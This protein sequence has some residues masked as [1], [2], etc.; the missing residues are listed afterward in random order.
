[1][2]EIKNVAV[3]GASGTLGPSVV[4]QLLKAGFHVTAVSR[5]GSSSTPPSGVSTASAD[6]ESIDS[7]ASVFKDQ[8]AVVSVVGSPGLP[9]QHILVDAAIKAGTSQLPVFQGKVSTRKYLSEKASA[10]E[11]TWTALITGPFLDKGISTGFVVNVKGGPTRLYDGGD[12]KRSMTT[13]EDIGKAVAGILKHPEETKNR[14]VY[15]QSTVT[16]Q[17][18]LL[19]LAKKA[20]PNLQ[21]EPQ[22]VDTAELEK[23]AY[24]DLKS[25]SGDIGMTMVTFII[26]ALWAEGYGSLF[27][28]TDNELLGVKEK[29]EEELA[30]L[31]KSLA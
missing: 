25:G 4:E 27:E 5:S 23:K 19:E 3:V 14:A 10:G 26:V 1:M 9:K 31:V 30:Q 16:T 29:S 24:S 7:L 11:I 6:Y 13:L 12:K 22:E 18:H 8:D 28:K 21:A 20:K 2:S 17:K 15:V